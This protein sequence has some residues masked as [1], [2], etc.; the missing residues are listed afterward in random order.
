MQRVIWDRVSVLVVA[1]LI[2]ACATTPAPQSKLDERARQ[3]ALA[4]AHKAIGQRRWPLPA[5]YKVIVE[6]SEFTPE[7]QPSWYED[8]VT[9][10]QPRPNKSAAP[11]YSVTI[12]AS[13][14]EVTAVDDERKNVQSEEVAAACRAFEH[15]YHLTRKDYTTTAGPNDHTVEVTFLLDAVRRRPGKLTPQRTVVAVV[16]RATLRITSLRERP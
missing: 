16:D 5:G 14:G 3:A 11:L 2:G 15:A 13:T 12:R 7:L 10:T 1:G 8:V 9:F 4:K 6:R